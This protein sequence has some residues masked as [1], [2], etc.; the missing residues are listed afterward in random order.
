MKFSIVIPVY[1]A[2]DDLPNCLQSVFRQSLQDWEIL[3]CD[4]GSTDG[5]TGALCD[6][7]S[8]QNPEKIR[9]IHRKNGGPG[10]ARN[11]GVD[12]ARGEYICFLDSDDHLAPDALKK[13]SQR[14]TETHADLIELGFYTERD[15]VT[16][17]AFP[18]AAPA[19]KTV[20]LAEMP[21]LMFSAASPWR[22]IYRREFFMNAAV[23]FPE[24]VLIA[25]DLRLTLRL[26][27]LAESITAV[28]DC[29]YYYVDRPGSI[30]RQGDPSR[31]R[32]LICAIDD[33]TEWYQS[34]GFYS[35]YQSELTRLAVEHLMLACSVRVLRADPDSPLLEEIRDYMESHFPGYAENPYVLQLSRAQKLALR[36]LQGRRYRTVK[37]L[38]SLKDRLS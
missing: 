30:S 33:I 27:P 4:D 11:T 6:S 12:A 23:R 3:L 18:P 31:N 35:Q 14:I 15:G 38:F 5:V 34:Q 37:A 9:V 32:Q 1:N 22:R 17:E 8:E 16:T 24:G 26:L 7:Y 28:P 13:L 19:D 36:L 20:T 10:A 21:T 25:E 2:A 29:L